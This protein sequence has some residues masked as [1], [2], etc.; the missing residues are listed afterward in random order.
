LSFEYTFEF[1]N[2]SVFFA[3]SVP[4]TYSMLLKELGE[5]EALPE[6]EKYYTRSKLCDTLAGN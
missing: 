4:Y 3:H 2:D 6:I 5:I 1:D